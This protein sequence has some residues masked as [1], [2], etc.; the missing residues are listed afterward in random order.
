MQACAGLGRERR[1]SG[2][3]A[4]C[5]VRRKSAR[6]VETLPA[7]VVCVPC[8][9]LL[10]R[11]GHGGARPRGL[12]RGAAQQRNAPLQAG[13]QH[14]LPVGLLR[15]VHRLLRL[16]REYGP[17]QGA[18]WRS[19]PPLF[20]LLG[21]PACAGGAA[22]PAV[23]SPLRAATTSAPA[24]IRRGG[25]ATKARSSVVLLRA[26]SGWTNLASA[27]TARA[28]PNATDAST[29]G[30]GSRGVEDEISLTAP[31]QPLPHTG[32]GPVRSACG[33]RS[34]ASAGAAMRP[35]VHSTRM[36][37]ARAFTI[38]SNAALRSVP[39]LCAASSRRVA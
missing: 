18:C 23:A 6:K 37:C 10:A 28:S 17:E 34:R 8:D 29:V 12:V 11:G 26:T 14:H 31:S 1:A 5:G 27:R 9:A 16:H 38:A 19:T 7:L 21:Q 30:S 15:L 25:R 20:L 22:A 3:R 36:M 39:P 35:L 33:A 4:L 24:L 32:I 13:R 2:E